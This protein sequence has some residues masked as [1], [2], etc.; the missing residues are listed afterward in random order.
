[1]I[2]PT[3]DRSTAD[4]EL[5]G[6]ALF[7]DATALTTGGLLAGA[8]LD[9]N[10]LGGPL[11]DAVDAAGD[12]TTLALVAAD[13]AWFEPE[14]ADNSRLTTPADVDQTNPCR[15]AGWVRAAGIPHSLPA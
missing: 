8:A 7:G 2:G 10:A 15:R 11:A 6:D 1:M 5:V 12:E 13:A 3:V 14:H 9:A 4:G